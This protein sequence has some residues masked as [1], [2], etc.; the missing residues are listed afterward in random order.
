MVELDKYYVR[1]SMRTKDPNNHYDTETGI[2]GSC[3]GFCNLRP[4]RI[5][6]GQSWGRY[7]WDIIAHL[8]F[9]HF[10]KPDLVFCCI[11]IGSPSWTWIVYTSCKCRCNFPRK[12]GVYLVYKHGLRFS[13]WTPGVPFLRVKKGPLQ[14]VKVAFSSLSEIAL[15][16]VEA[17]IQDQ[18]HQ[19]SENSLGFLIL[20][21][22][23]RS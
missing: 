18:F 13:F 12:L 17:Q 2:P 23:T 11:C 10:Y 1:Y 15:Q 20:V 14:Q 6:R 22:E 16:V 19:A 9:L 3:L 5:A 4:E 8:Y 7:S 21:R